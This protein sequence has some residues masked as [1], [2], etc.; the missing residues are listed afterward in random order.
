MRHSAC[1]NPGSTHI[2]KMY[3]S[4]VGKTSPGIIGKWPDRGWRPVTSPAVRF[5][6]VGWV[7]WW[8]AAS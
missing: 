5:Q 1:Q 4:A 8:I 6:A 3:A 7:N 2:G